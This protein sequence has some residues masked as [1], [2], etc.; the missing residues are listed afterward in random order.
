MYDTLAHF[1]GAYLHQ[2][3]VDDYADLAGVVAD[4]VSSEPPEAVA[5]LIADIDVV[6]HRF[7]PDEDVLRWLLVERMGSNY[8]AEA[9]SMT[10]AQWLMRIRVLLIVH[11]DSPDTP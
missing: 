6:L 5:W 2:D 1:A 9:D 3:W 8:A 11:S 7:T 4:F 10:Y